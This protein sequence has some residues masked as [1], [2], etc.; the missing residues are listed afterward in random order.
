MRL[1]AAGVMFND[2]CVGAAVHG[3]RL[4][5]EQQQRGTQCARTPGGGRVGTMSGR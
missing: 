4:K 1:T 5:V 3:G 2:A